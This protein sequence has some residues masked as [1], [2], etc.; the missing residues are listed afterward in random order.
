MRE[1]NLGNHCLGSCGYNGKEEKWALEDQDYIDND[2]LNPYDKYASREARNFVR[3][4]FCKLDEN[5]ELVTD[6]KVV[7]GVRLDADPRVL[8]LEKEVVSNLPA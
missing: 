4:R 7:Q 1:L 2:M 6:P 5:G 3:S 8:A